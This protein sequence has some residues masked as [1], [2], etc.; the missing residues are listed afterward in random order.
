MLEPKTEEFEIT[1]QRLAESTVAATYSVKVICVR[2]D[3]SSILL[4]SR[5]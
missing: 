1:L 5:V 2:D 4:R 3:G